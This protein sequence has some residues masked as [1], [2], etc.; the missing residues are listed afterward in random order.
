MPRAACFVAARPISSATRSPAPAPP[1]LTELRLR[2]ARL[3]LGTASRLPGAGR[4][5]LAAMPTPA[6]DYARRMLSTEASVADRKPAAASEAPRPAATSTPAKPAAEDGAVPPPPIQNEVGSTAAAESAAA[7]AKTAKAASTAEQF[8]ARAA[9]AM[10]SRPQAPASIRDAGIN[11]ATMWA[12]T[13]EALKTLPGVITKFVA[14][15]LIK[16]PAQTMMW[17]I[18]DRPKFKARMNY[19]WDAIKHEAQHYYLGFKLLGVDAKTAYGLVKRVLNGKQL[20]RR[21]RRQLMRTTSDLF[22]LVP[23]SIFIIVPG[24]EALIPIALKIYPDLLPSTFKTQ[25]AKAAEQKKALQMRVEL[26]TF[27]QDTMEFMG[28]KAGPGKAG[29]QADS[30]A[31]SK[32]VELV[33]GARAGRVLEA[34]DIVQVSRLFKDELTLENVGRHEL[35]AM[36]RFLGLATYGTDGFLRYQ[37]RSRIKAIKVDDTEIK[38]EGLE[39]LSKEEL[40]EACRER[41]MRSTGLTEGGLR[42]QLEQWL[43]LS[44]RK[45]VPLSL[46]ILSRAL[47]F[48]A[49]STKEASPATP[50]AQPA[51]AAQP[52]PSKPKSKADAPAPA[53]A[54]VAPSTNMERALQDSIAHLGSTIVEEALLGAV[55]GGADGDGLAV[56]QMRLRSLERENELI[57]MERRAKEAAATAHSLAKEAEEK[58]NAVEGVRRSGDEE[59]LAAAIV[60]ASSTAQAAAAAGQKAKEAYVELRKVAAGEMAEAVARRRRKRRA[61]KEGSAA[62]AA[63]DEEEDDGAGTPV[64]PELMAALSGDSGIRA[65]VDAA[66]R[67]QSS[68]DAERGMPPPAADDDDSV[69]ADLLELGKEEAEA[70]LAM[71]SATALQHERA[72]ISRIKAARLRIEASEMLARGRI[73]AAKTVKAG[74][75]EEHG[76][77]AHDAAAKLGKDTANTRVSSALDNLLNRLEDDLEAA[78]ESLGSALTLLDQ[79]RDGIVSAEEL[80]KAIMDVLGNKNM[81]SAAA[82][83]VK[84]LDADRDGAITIE[85]VKRYAQLRAQAEAEADWMHPGE[86]RRAVDQA[87]G[88]IDEEGEASSTAQ[89]ANANSDD[90]DEDDYDD[91][92]E[93]QAVLRAAEASTAA[94]KRASSAAAAAAEDLDSRR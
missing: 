57:E 77:G 6:L 40:A 34:A 14:E 72:S 19:I 3:A 4:L 86:V 68:A 39:A 23:F 83:I 10:T 41:G 47:T 70:L 26:A 67:L 90:E 44:T 31:S 63:D 87:R 52:A 81:E 88:D 45:E 92:A 62:S 5:Q 22:R 89:A 32:L 35:M 28:T 7:D 59:Q 16:Y 1:A 61:A 60:A 29:D 74:A 43:D 21:E 85:E 58:A 94:A 56:R 8:A 65:L 50:S 37:L 18:T 20:T 73:D 11:L 48:A 49:P 82:A 17:A 9:S 79:D 78:D 2:S 84:R 46:L 51:S 13:R 15:Y 27:L 69:A 25:D 42:D 64:D 55:D 93:R 33:Q 53:A 71:A 54:P 30:T 66:S 91:E 36:A 75:H 76:D 38:R 24:G 80:Q 12:K